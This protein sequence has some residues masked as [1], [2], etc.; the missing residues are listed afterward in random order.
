MNPVIIGVTLFITAQLGIGIAVSRFVRTEDDYFLAGR[1][2]GPLLATFSIF[3]TWFG[4]ESVIGSAGMAY[5]E[6]M[7]GV[8]S[9]PF[10]Y[11][12]CILIAG[13]FFARVFWDMKL[14]TVADFVR[15]RFSKRAARITAALMVPTSFLWTAAQIRA[16]GTVLSSATDIS[17]AA[18][19]VAATAIVLLYTSFG[20]MLADVVTDLLQGTILIIGLGFVLYF[21]AEESGGIA[22]FAGSV[23][24][25][26]RLHDGSAGGN[27]LLTAE[28]W[29]IPVCGSIFAQELISRMLSSRST[30]TAVRA[31]LTAGTMYILIGFIPLSLG[32]AGASL[33]PGLSDGEQVLP[34]LA[35][36]FLPPAMFI[37]FSGAIISAILSTV[38]ST[39]LAI[40]ALLSHNVFPM[41][42]DLPERTKVAVDRTIV[43]VAGIA[44]AFFALGADGVYELVKDASSFGSAGIFVVMMAGLYSQ[45]GDGTTASATLLIGAVTWGAAHYIFHFE[46][47]YL[48]SLIVSLLVF[49]VAEISRTRL[50]AGRL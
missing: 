49:V 10:G 40:S 5:D 37:I 43:I 33:I 21:V 18:G 6:G 35:R 45:R 32:L 47:S 41:R 19:V 31:S 50:S 24:S 14:V 9:D 17:L 16:F 11:G 44:A 38:D 48:L 36:R 34:E 26:V 42:N 2:L 28:R 30:A 29:L 13:L 20:G 8:S 23:L 12:L 22:A 3:A 25:G 4:A 15:H 27:P 39:L 7:A 46:L 1:R